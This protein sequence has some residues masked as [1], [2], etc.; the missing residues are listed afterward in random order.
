MPDVWAGTTPHTRKWMPVT[1][2]ASAAA[3]E[4]EPENLRRAEEFA[5]ISREL[6]AE[7]S[8]QPTLERIVELA[9]ETIPACQF[10]GISF[11]YPDGTIETPACSAE[12]VGQADVLQYEFGEGPCL[13]AIWSTDVLVIGDLKAERRWPKWAPGA[14]ELGLTSTL[15]VRISTPSV[16][17]GGL[18]L[19]SSERD[20]FDSTDEAVASIFARHAAD[21]LANAEELAGLR[22]A[23]RSRQLIGVAQGILMQRFELGLDQSFEVLRRYSQNENIKLRDLAEQLVRVGRIPAGQTVLLEEAEGRS[24]DG[25]R[26][27]DPSPLT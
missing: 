26:S 9:V 14:A 23:L 22:T 19:Y 16:T 24:E 12:V 5:R 17:F 20:A 21:A 18:N 25:T 7:P 15:S 10:C 11:R 2:Q 13:D 6:H 27:T 1:D 8:P 4:D 3:G